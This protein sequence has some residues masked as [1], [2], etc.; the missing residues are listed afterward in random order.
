[1]VRDVMSENIGRYVS[2]ALLELS[3]GF[4]DG[5]DFPSREVHAGAL[6]LTDISGW[7]RLTTVLASQGGA[8]IERASRLLND[9]FSDLIELVE[10][11][12]G[13]VFSFAGDSLLAGWPVDST[14]PSLSTA[15]LRACECALAIKRRFS[16]HHTGEQEFRVR[17]SVGAG[18][19]S[20]LHVGEPSRRVF[21]LVDGAAHAQASAAGTSA[22]A[23]EVLVSKEAW[24]LVADH[25]EGEQKTTAAIHLRQVSGSG[26]PMPRR[27]KKKTLARTRDLRAY[28]PKAL[29]ER[30][31]SPLPA[32]LGELRAVTVCF[33]Q[34]IDTQGTADLL[35][36][37][38]L[39]LSVLETVERLGGDLLQI[40]TIERGVN[41]L[42]VFGLPGESHEDDPRRLLLASLEIQASATQ[43]HWGVSGG[44]TT[45]QVFC[46]VV[47]G[48]RFAEYRVLGDVVNLAAR[49]VT[50]AAGRIM[51]D[52][53]TAGAAKNAIQFD[54]PWPL[55]IPGFRRAFKV[56]IP[57]APLQLAETQTPA[58]LVD[59]E[60]EL[61]L[62]VECL[63]NIDPVRQIVVMISGEPGIGKS[64]LVT[65]LAGESLKSGIPVFKGSTDALEQTTPFFVWLAIIRTALNID[66]LPSGQ[67]AEETA[68]SA[69]YE[70]GEIA[71]F[72]P[73]LN[74]VLSFKIKDNA[75]T[76]RMTSE[77]RAKNLR[78]LLAWV[79]SNSLRE[80][81]ALLILEDIHWI[82]KASLILL[83]DILTSTKGV[84]VVL[85]SRQLASALT[86]EQLCSQFADE[87]IQLPLDRLKDTDSLSLAR[88]ALSRKSIPR[89]LESAVIDSSGGNPLFIGELCRVFEQM[90]ANDS[91]RQASGAALPIPWPPPKSI[92]SV[93]LS[94]IDNLPAEPR[95]LIKIISVAGAHF[96]VE[97]LQT[98][99]PVVLAEINV[100]GAI[101]QLVER[102]LLEEIPE[103]SRHYRFRHAIIRDVVYESMLTTQ[104]QE[105]HT[106]VAEALEAKLG[107]DAASMPLILQHW[108]GAD[109]TANVMTYLDKVAELKLKQ[110]DNTAAISLIQ[111]LFSL[112]NLSARGLTHQRQAKCELIIADAAKSAGQMEL[113]RRSYEKGLALLGMPV[114]VSTSG[115][116]MFLARE[117]LIQVWNRLFPRDQ[118]TVS[119]TT[120]STERED[121][122][123]AARAHDA[124]TQIYY[125]AGEKVRLLH[126]TLRATNLAERFHELTP[127]LA[128][129][130]S[131]L[132]AICGVIPLRRDAEYYTARAA[133]IVRR[134]NDPVASIHVHLLAGLYRTAVGDWIRAR[135]EFEPGI[136]LSLTL[137]DMRK[138]SEL[139]VG[140][141][142]ISGPWLL[143]SSF[144]GIDTWH[145]LI[146]QICANGHER[147]DL[148][149]LAC[150]LLGAVRGSR[151]LNRYQDEEQE[152]LAE[153]E[154]LVDGHTAD[155]ELI[156]CVEAAGL[157]ANAAWRR[158]DHD[159]WS[160]WLRQAQRFMG[161][162]NPG[163]KSRT[164]PALAA[165]FDSCVDWREARVESKSI[166]SQHID[167]ADDAVK[168]LKHFSRIYPIGRPAALRCEGDL[169]LVHGNQEKGA[170]FWKQ[171]LRSAIALGMPR[172][173]V[174]ALDRLNTVG[175]A[176]EAL[177][178]EVE[179][180]LRQ[181]D[182]GWLTVVRKH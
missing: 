113:S 2:D 108:R 1:M 63:R 15:T 61:R 107:N 158:G 14:C 148:Q 168:K 156:H 40:E 80:R 155:L 18:E 109:D 139:A 157:L 9:F 57:V 103:L 73:L 79:V 167:I 140:L 120:S 41:L 47:G 162:V 65:A 119:K 5:S 49:F 20:F 165:V 171:S 4:A 44:I 28:L 159:T 135:D 154:Q 128:I 13:A 45:G 27:R 91:N 161:N 142:T 72:A 75:F 64:A 12:G 131:S 134:F 141:E 145:A 31:K 146:S 104:R 125:F 127:T 117:A 98:L 37:N 138:W 39:V 59:R 95:T 33:L 126:A 169:R 25:C 137:G 129:S 66:D 115:L 42:I 174:A 30:L 124:L 56:Y 85:T 68:E 8:G 93:V 106:A 76:A 123:A 78:Q 96:S 160:A 180:M 62:L 179:I 32:W 130:Y 100:A 53:E 97:E 88:Q 94:R 92:E 77:V 16:Q 82:D 35:R 178:D 43:A 7:T 11:Q 110:Y 163:M 176:N 48:A 29:S 67:S 144:T 136:D 69:L 83:E 84:M 133:N 55:Q 132:G 74:D 172:D 58:P 177:N 10:S 6:L 54:G 87:G 166:C 149:V 105:A 111:E 99:R 152:Q 90:D 3:T 22:D 116:A 71:R 102:H 151:V 170:R 26:A 112:S 150:G 34:L 81:S 164:L 86:E 143:T 23:D 36:I 70:A 21:F 122:L 50:V 17:L 182:S 114:P 121:F 181:D 52:Q 173:A 46:G 19:M 51:A 24:Q 101:K 38:S 118:P 147:G 89:R 175:A 60:Q 153:L